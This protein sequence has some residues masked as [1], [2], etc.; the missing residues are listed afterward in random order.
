MSNKFLR[1]MFCGDLFDQAIGIKSNHDAPKITRSSSSTSSKF[2]FTSIFAQPHGK[3][4]TEYLWIFRSSTKLRFQWVKNQVN[5][6]IIQADMVESSKIA[7]SGIFLTACKSRNKKAI[8]PSFGLRLIWMSTRLKIHEEEAAATWW[9]RD[10]GDEDDD[11]K[12]KLGR[13]FH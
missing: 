10:N 4:K 9:E 5:R 1:L 13:W 3:K 12:E 8:V 2:L 7:R 6:R 11:N